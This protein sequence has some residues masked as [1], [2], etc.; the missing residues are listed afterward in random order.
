MGGEGNDVGNAAVVEIHVARAAENK[1]EDVGG[2]LLLE[3]RVTDAM[4]N[5]WGVKGNGAPQKHVRSDVY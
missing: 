1:G 2:T 3:P 4:E 5:K